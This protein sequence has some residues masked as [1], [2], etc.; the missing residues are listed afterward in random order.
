MAV[1]SAAKRYASAGTGEEAAAETDNL[2]RVE[3]LDAED[4]EDSE[5]TRR[6]S[7]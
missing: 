4:V 2:V 7:L 5:S 3:G 6:V 1:V